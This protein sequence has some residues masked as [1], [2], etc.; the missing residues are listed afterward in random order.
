MSSATEQFVGTKE[1]PDALQFD[2]ARVGDYL[3]AHVEGFRGPFTV[4]QFR[5]G[6]SNPTYLIDAA[7]GRYVMRRKPPGQLLPSAHAVDREYR[8]IKALHEAGFPVPRAYCLC[9]D[10]SLAGT[11][12]YV[13]GYVEGRVIWDGS[14][15]GETPANRRAMFE[16]WGDTLADLHNLDYVALELEDFGRPGNYF[17]RQISR[18]SKQFKASQTQNA[19]KMDRLI[20]W[21]PEHIPQ[22]DSVSLVHGDLSLHNVMFHPTEPRVVAVLDW[23]ISTIGHPLADLT[24]NMLAWYAPSTPGAIAS[25]LDLDLGALGIPTMDAYLKR[26]CERTG[27]AAVEGM[28]YYCAYNLFRIAAILQGIVGRVRDGTASN[29]NAE[30]MAAHV[31]PLSELAW[32]YALKAGA[33]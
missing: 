33:R 21:L 28:D 9:E 27:R 24:Y 12:F 3:Q 10:E 15:P 19:E 18:W 1:V 7:S 2:Q 20:E 11:I 32:E 25:L 29:E 14:M 17:A 13:M 22:E 6:Q 8:V 30:A 26:Y 4:T 23:E 31:L 16:S 5:G